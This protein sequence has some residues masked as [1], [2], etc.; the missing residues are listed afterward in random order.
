M[1]GHCSRALAD[2]TVGK[3]R[4]AFSHVHENRVGRRVHCDSCCL[5]GADQAVGG[6]QR[7]VLVSLLRQEFECPTYP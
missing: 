1:P 2:L 4:G 5:V 7:G 3:T 6:R